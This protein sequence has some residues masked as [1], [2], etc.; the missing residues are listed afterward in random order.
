LGSQIVV[1]D[2]RAEGLESSQVVLLAKRLHLQLH[3]WIT[4]ADD[5][6][7]TTP[8][9]HQS[10]GLLKRQGRQNLSA[11]SV[12]VNR[13]SGRQTGALGIREGK[14]AWTEAPSM[15]PWARTWR[16]IAA[17]AHFGGHWLS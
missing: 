4:L 14:Q 6:T 3:A 9:G 15:I 11:S 7:E 1:G 8:V 13:V 17:Q 2:G 16:V 5:L 12:L 10:L